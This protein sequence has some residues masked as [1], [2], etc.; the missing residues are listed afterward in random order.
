MTT[1]EGLA[2]FSGRG[3]GSDAERRAAN[4]LA[5]RCAAAGYDVTQETFWCRPNWALAQLWHVALAITGSLVTLASPIV[6]I[7]L[8][9]VALACVVADGLAGVS[10]GRRLTPE[11]ASQNVL[12]RRAGERPG[13]PRARLLLTANYDAGRIGLAYRLRPSSSR[14]TRALNGLAPGWLGWLLL[15]IIWLIV[16][17]ILRE[18]GHTSKVVGAVQLIP[19]AGLLIG[20]ALLLELAGGHWSPSAG[21]NASGVATVLHLAEL[22][23]ENAPGN[24]QVELLLTGAG[25]A[26]QIGLRRHLRARRTQPG[27]RLRRLRRTTRQAA[28]TIVL[29]VA[30]CAGATPSWWQSDG[31]LLPL[32]YSAALRRTARQVAEEESHLQAHPHRSRGNSTALPARMAGLPALTV[33]CL[34]SCGTAPRSHQRTDLPEA[35]ERRALDHGIQFALLIID[36]IDAALARGERAS[37]ATPA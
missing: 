36:G 26:E 9:A 33:G 7:A 18:D 24:L 14:L 5:T 12:A 27:A 16:V 15:G 10:P 32:R 3:A 31:A 30:A 37:T 20:F 13:P 11:R 1:V 23:A 34:D 35:V 4:W 25:D 17:A 21:D 22:L 19:T 6:G 8:L 28:D 2:A 29:G